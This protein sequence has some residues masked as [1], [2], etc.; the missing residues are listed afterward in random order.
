[1]QQDTKIVLIFCAIILA[2]LS[3]GAYKNLTRNSSYTSNQDT[4]QAVTIS[5]GVQKIAIA[6]Q[7]GY[8][9]N[10]ITAQAG[11]PTELVFTTDGTYDCSASLVIPSL[12]YRKMLS[13]TGEESILLTADQATGTLRGACSMGMYSFSI[14]FE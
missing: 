5:D 3:F 14:V 7:G 9:P 11:V 13:S 1:M 8:T 4:Q 6:V 10:R 2:L 12:H